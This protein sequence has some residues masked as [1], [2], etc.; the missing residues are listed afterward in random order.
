M[1]LN[2]AMGMGLRD[3]GSQRL[4]PEPLPRSARAPARMMRAIRKAPVAPVDVPLA[5]SSPPALKRAALQRLNEM[6]FMRS[7]YAPAKRTTNQQRSYEPGI[8]SAADP[9]DQRTGTRHDNA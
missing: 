7:H 6:G 5:I 4:W 3:G 8:V 2:S 9:D 1:R